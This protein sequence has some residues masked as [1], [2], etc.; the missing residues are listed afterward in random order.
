MKELLVRLWND[1]S[2]FTSSIRGLLFIGVGLAA[3]LGYLDATTAAV[4]QG[5]TLMVPAGEKNVSGSTQ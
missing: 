2:F 1:S 5:G 4:L 3:A